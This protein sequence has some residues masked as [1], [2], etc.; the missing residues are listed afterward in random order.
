[1]LNKNIPHLSTKKTLIFKNFCNTIIWFIW[2]FC[3]LKFNEDKFPSI[4]A[5]LPASLSMD[6]S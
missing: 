6:V 3:A 4:S 2:F 1:V 5:L